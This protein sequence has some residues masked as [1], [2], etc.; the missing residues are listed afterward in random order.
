MEYVER[1]FSTLTRN[2]GLF[3]VP[4]V[5]DLISFLMGL[6]TVGFVG[7]AA[8]TFKFSVNVGLLSIADILEHYVMMNGLV[9]N[10]DE[11]LGIMGPAL[12]LFAVFMIFSA[13]V[14]AGFV[15]LLYD[16][17]RRQS[18]SSGQFFA[19]AGRYWPRFLG[20]RL[21]ILAFIFIGGLVSALVLSILGVLLFLVVFVILR[22]R[23]IYWEFTIV[24]EDMGVIDAFTRSR[25]H[26]AN[27]SHHLA[28]VIITI[29]VSNFIFGLIFNGIWHPVVVFVGIFIYGY[30][31]SG[32]QL[33]LMFTKP[34]LDIEAE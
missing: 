14:E 30:V 5:M 9:F 2:L 12:L 16:V 17:V 10:L 28:G 33:A 31:A 29:L 19:Y 6:A 11:G 18:V 23:Y 26:F 13:F 27:R 1:G 24:S 20:L 22:I 8:F 34:D 4:V 25:E 3:I 7:E 15:G 32:L 21:L